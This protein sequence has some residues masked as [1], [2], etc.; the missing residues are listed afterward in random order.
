MAE[1][2]PSDIPEV[3]VLGQ[4]GKIHSGHFAHPPLNFT[5][6]KKWRI[7]AQCSTPVY[8]EQ[9]SYRSSKTKFPDFSSQSHNIF[10]DLYRHK[11]YYG[12]CTI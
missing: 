11:F 3:R 7:L 12:N 5:R 1:Q 4:T 6:V 8:F 9:G 2:Q 10:P